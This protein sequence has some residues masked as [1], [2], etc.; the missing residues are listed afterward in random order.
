M[1]IEGRA[2]KGNKSNSMGVPNKYRPSSPDSP[3]KACNLRHWQ[4]SDTDT[5]DFHFVTPSLV[6]H[7][8]PALIPASCPCDLFSTVT[9]PLIFMHTCWYFTLLI[10][11]TCEVRLF[12]LIEQPLSH[13]SHS[14]ALPALM[15]N[16]TFMIWLRATV[17]GKTALLLVPMTGASSYATYA[18]CCRHTLS[19]TQVYF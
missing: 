4:T 19:E 18:D 15:M 5:G 9:Y 2:M 16:V 14:A 17:L 3:C 12:N 8:S 13:V 7:P 1:E 11:P 10:V 6:N